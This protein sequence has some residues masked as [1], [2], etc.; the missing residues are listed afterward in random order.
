MINKSGDEAKNLK[1]LMLNS[2]IMSK[3]QNSIKRIMGELGG[4]LNIKTKSKSNAVMSNLWS[5]RVG[6]QLIDHYLGNLSSKHIL[7]FYLIRK[8]RMY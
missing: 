8:K 1:R 7:I 5:G 6:K 3:P 2:K 4:E